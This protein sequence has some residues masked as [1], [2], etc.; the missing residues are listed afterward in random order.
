MSVVQ[1]QFAHRNRRGP[2]LSSKA[3]GDAAAP[4]AMC[5]ADEEFVAFVAANYARLLH[6]AELILGDRGHAEDA[7]QTVLTRTYLRWRKVRQANPL[8]YVRKGL[9]NTHIDWWRRGM[10]RDRPTEALP[11]DRAEPDH[12]GRVVGRDAVLRAL[13]ALT[14]RERAVVVLRFYEDLSEA[15]IARTLAV[16]PGT[17]KST[18]AR[19]LTKLRIS[20]ELTPS[21]EPADS[22][23][24]DQWKADDSANR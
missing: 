24:T 22:L 16:A 21:A 18:C 5:S 11:D 8:G 1:G 2:R 3:P 23:R 6:V 9:V 13:A 7:L 12:A 17:V 10:F 14:R 20:P 15:E 19:A 4:E